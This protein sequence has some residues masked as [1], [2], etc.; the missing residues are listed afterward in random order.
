MH[1]SGGYI[2]I[3]HLEALQLQWQHAFVHQICSI[4]VPVP[5]TGS[6]LSNAAYMHVVTNDLIAKTGIQTRRG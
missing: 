1:D 3:D 5:C 6:Y 4:Y 2:R